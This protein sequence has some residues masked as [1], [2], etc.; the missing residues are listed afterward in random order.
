MLQLLEL[1]EIL[2]WVA[3]FTA[4]FSTGIYYYL[5]QTIFP[6]WSLFKIVTLAPIVASLLIAAALSDVVFK[7]IWR[8]LRRWNKLLYP[9]LTGCWEGRIVPTSGESLV[10]RANIRHSPVGIQIDF[11]G[12]TFKSITLVATP[13]VDQGQHYLYYVYH[14]ESKDPKRPPY[15]GTAILRVRTKGELEQSIHLLSGPYYTTRKTVGNIE[16]RQVSS[17][18]DQDMSF[19]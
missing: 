9:D 18:P 16:L 2:K 8:L 6:D 1:R 19:Y 7:R 4:G 14:S 5:Q 12:E 11:H 3:I 10:V 17:D 15:D 13:T